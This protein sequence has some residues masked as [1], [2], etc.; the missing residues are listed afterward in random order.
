MPRIAAVCAIV[1]LAAVGIGPKEGNA[2]E[3]GT[4][5][6]SLIGVTPVYERHALFG[7]VQTPPKG[8]AWFEVYLE[9][10]CAAGAESSF[11]VIRGD[12]VVLTGSDGGELHPLDPSLGR[13]PREPA[14]VESIT[15]SC[16]GKC[17]THPFILLFQLKGKTTPVSLK[18][19]PDEFNL[20]AQKMSKQGWK[21]MEKPSKCGATTYKP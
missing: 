8:T 16:N 4:S 6:L 7:K 19:G 5:K 9:H 3:T 2:Q 13:E 14:P 20:V 1:G 21:K 10:S 12:S 15:L 18:I 11:P 17:E